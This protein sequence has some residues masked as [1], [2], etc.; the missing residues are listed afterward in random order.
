MSIASGP[1]VKIGSESE[2]NVQL[3]SSR[4]LF[5]F[6][7]RS[8]NR[9]TRAG[10]IGD[11][12]RCWRHEVR[13]NLDPDLLISLTTVLRRTSLFF[14]AT[15]K[16]DMCLEDN[17]AQLFVKILCIRSFSEILRGH[18]ASSVHNPT[19]AKAN[20]EVDFVNLCIYGLLINLIGFHFCSYQNLCS[21]RCC[22]LLEYSDM[23]PSM[24]LFQRI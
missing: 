7:L 20:K 17:V 3:D 9:Q 5:K 22:S 21:M 19:A 14:I 24:C 13:A 15:F 18:Q 23:I 4:G 1:P 2:F 12:V 16:L 6:Y 10:Y 11:W 8:S